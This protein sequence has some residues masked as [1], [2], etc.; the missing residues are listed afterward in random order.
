MRLDDLERDRETETDAAGGIRTVACSDEEPLE[1]SRLMLGLD[2][3]A[4][5]GDRPRHVAVSRGDGD[6][7]RTAVRRVLPGI[8][9]EVHEGLLE[10]AIVAEDRDGLGRGI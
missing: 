6:P 5:V 8:R 9:Q 4:V 10:A 3:L 7:D 1:Q 2:A